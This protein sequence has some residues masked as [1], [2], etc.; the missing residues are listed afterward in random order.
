MKSRL[1]FPLIPLFLLGLLLVTSCDK[2]LKK[3]NPSSKVYCDTSVVIINEAAVE[4]YTHKTQYAPSEI[5][6]FKIHCLTPTHRIEVFRHGM[7]DVKVHDANGLSSLQQNYHCYSYSYGCHWKTTHHLPVPPTWK[8]GIYSARITDE[9]GNLNW[10]NFIITKAAGT[11]GKD[12]AMLAST[13][14][15]QAYND[16]GG[17][18]FYDFEM[19]ENVLSSLNISFQRPNKYATPEARGGH[20]LA[21]ELHLVRWLD[22]N[23]FQWDQYTDRNLHDD[24]YLLEPYK[25]VIIQT[26]PEYYTKQM[27]DRLYRYVQNGGRLMYLGGNG[28]WG[29]VVIDTNRDILEIRRGGDSH[30]FESSVGGLWRELGQSESGLLGVQYDER[31]YLS[32]HPYQVIQPN[33]WVFEGTGLSPN[34][35]FGSPCE[36]TDGASGHETDKITSVSTKIPTLQWLAKGINPNKGGADMIYYTTTAGGQVFAVGSISYTSCLNKDSTISIIT[37]NVLKRFLEP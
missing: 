1:R 24:E 7:V 33:H 37:R 15:W 2:V 8:P 29:K 12:I 34:D 6:E 28:I 32:W 25:V 18:S 22:R 17:G 27:Y 4:G 5:I 16:W 21:A 30:T 9:D 10:L 14:T 23:G 31:G 35:L 36:D 3:N 13:N 19:D 26:H 20:L 11:P